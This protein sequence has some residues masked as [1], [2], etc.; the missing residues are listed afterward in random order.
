MC[1]LS[2]PPLQEQLQSSISFLF[3][4]M[5]L[6][7]YIATPPSLS[8]ALSSPLLCHF[9]S[10]SGSCMLSFASLHCLSWPASTVRSM[11]D[12]KKQ[13]PG[14]RCGMCCLS[15]VTIRFPF[16][17]SHPPSL[18]LYASCSNVLTCKITHQLTHKWGSKVHDFTG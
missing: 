4:R 10:L 1:S 9:S 11:R 3:P 8:L 16:S 17:L 15:T 5:S 12:R 7:Q 18:C 6:S 13:R 14:Q 2:C